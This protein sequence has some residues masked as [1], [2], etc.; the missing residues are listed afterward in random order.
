MVLGLSPRVSADGAEITLSGTGWWQDR[1]LRR[2]LAELDNKDDGTVIT[3]NEVEDAVFFAMSSVSAEGYLR[4][5]IEA[6]ILRESGETITHQFDVEFLDL[7]PRP[8]RAVKVALKVNRG[9]RYTFHDVKF[10]GDLSILDSERA[11]ALLNPRTGLL[12]RR[13]DATFAPALLRAGVEQIRFELERQGYAE[14]KVEV[15]AERRN[16]ENGEVDV[17]I[18]IEPGARWLIAA[19]EMSGDADLGMRLAESA[20]IVGES[21][22][23]AKE[24]DWTERVRRAYYLDGYPDVRL[25]VTHELGEV[26]GPQRPIRMMLT[27]SSGTQFTMGPAQFVGSHEVNETVLRR[28]TDLS[29]GDKLNPIEV[30]EARRRLQ[31]LQALRR[32]GIHYE[33]TGDSARVP[34]FSLEAR[35][36]WELSLLAGVGS[37]EQVRVGVELKGN[38]VF[39]RSHQLRL[40]AI[41]SL[42]SLRGDAVYTVPEIFGE[43]VDGNVRV[44][45]LDREELSFQRREYG[46]SVG[47]SRRRLPWINAEGIVD[48]TFQQLASEQNELGTRATDS[49]D[50]TTASLTLGLRRDRRDNPLLPRSGQRWA[51]QVEIAD[52]GFGGESAFQRLELGW[53]WHKAWQTDNWFHVGLS[54]GTI[55]TLGQAN[56]RNLPVN[57]RFFPGG[58]NS[59]RGLQTGGAVP[60]DA[61]GELVG[62]KSFTLLNLEFEQAFTRRFSAVVFWDSLGVTARVAEFP[63]QDTLHAVGGGLRYNTVIGPVRLEYGHNLNRRERDPSGTWHFSIGYP[64]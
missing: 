55:L 62:A 30:E 46:G 4:P 38:N 27:I 28:R 57:K 58:E 7:L 6:Q 33:P 40:E 2:A 26:D 22:T 44:F 12:G 23:Q 10:T 42:K 11:T 49:V 45:G 21:W 48:Y 17:D 64:F 13:R 56:D 53:S 18:S 1:A 25:E 50:S 37:Y 47:L 35:D 15:L 5:E 31:R 19:A 39:S 54:H 36:P 8:L 9:V 41:A 60:R 32:V 14:A 16:D 43:T 51:T 29:A 3:A 24:Q 59:Y 61:A 52:R 34:V 63:W 20:S